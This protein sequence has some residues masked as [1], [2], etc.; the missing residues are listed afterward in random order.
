MT[1]EEEIEETT[2][3]EEIPVDFL[4]TMCELGLGRG[5]DGREGGTHWSDRKRVDWRADS[6]SKYVNGWR[7]GRGGGEWGS[8][9]WTTMT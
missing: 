2:E 5:R 1:G 7:R 9:T 6:V 3:K 4:P 8:W